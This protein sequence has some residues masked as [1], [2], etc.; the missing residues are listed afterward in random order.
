MGCGKTTVGKLLAEKL[1]YQF[2]DTDQ[3]IE[4]R[5]GMSIP[6][7]FS[8]WGEKRFRT[9]EHEISEELAGR[10][11]LVISTGGRLMLDPDN[12]AH[13]EIIASS[14]RPS[15]EIQS[16]SLF[17]PSAGIVVPF[18]IEYQGAAVFPLKGIGVE[19]SLYVATV[20]KVSCMEFYLRD[21]RLIAVAMRENGS[22]IIA[23]DYTL[24]DE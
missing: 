13:L 21:D 10:R 1:D 22:Q 12:V 4:H 3:A 8:T 18:E 5:T 23:S 17:V 16:S 2:I 19:C 7:I 6:K 24:V 9:F 15:S 11:E 20:A 14:L